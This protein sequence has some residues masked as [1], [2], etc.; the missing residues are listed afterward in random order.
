MLARSESAIG[1]LAAAR[2]ID[3]YSVGFI[4]TFLATDL[5]ARLSR[6]GLASNAYFNAHMQLVSARIREVLSEHGIDSE[7]H[8]AL[9]W[10]WSKAERDAVPH[11]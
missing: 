1:K 5:Q 6:L 11:E 7:G 3:C 8:P 10:G 9:Q 2:R 4:S